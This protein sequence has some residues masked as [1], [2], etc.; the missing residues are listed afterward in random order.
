[1]LRYSSF[2]VIYIPDDEACVRLS[3]VWGDRLWHRCCCAPSTSDCAP[4]LLRVLCID[5]TIFR[6]T[7]RL[8]EEW[9][10]ICGIVLWICVSIIHLTTS[11]EDLDNKHSK[12]EISHPVRCHMVPGYR[13]TIQ[14]HSQ[15]WF[16]YV[17]ASELILHLHDVRDKK[18]CYQCPLPHCCT[19]LT[20]L[21]HLVLTSL[22]MPLCSQHNMVL[23][24][25]EIL[26]TL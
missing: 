13:N 24:Y 19:R 9:R 5:M 7:C 26:T 10:Y 3:I 11:E 6:F 20:R 15:L 18:H 25:Y 22:D 16:C 8:S 12:C 21:E 4:T 2:D 1:M 17:F 14:S 23:R